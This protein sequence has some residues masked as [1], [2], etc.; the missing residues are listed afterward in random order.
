MGTSQRGPNLTAGYLCP[1][2]VSALHRH[3]EYRDVFPIGS[4]IADWATWS[5]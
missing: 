3:P 1:G 2:S 5:A 4:S